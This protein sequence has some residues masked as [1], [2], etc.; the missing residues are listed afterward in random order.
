MLNESFSAGSA[1][2]IGQDESSLGTVSSTGNFPASPGKVDAEVVSSQKITLRTVSQTG[3]SFVL[4]D[5]ESVPLVARGSGTP[6]AS[7][8]TNLIVNPSLEN[9][10]TCWDYGNVAPA[11]AP[12]T[13][14][15]DTSWADTGQTS[16][17]VVTAPASGA[18]TSARIRPAGA[19]CEPSV[20]NG[21]PYS[22]QLRVHI[23]NIAGAS[24][25]MHAGLNWLDTSNT[26]LSGV[27]GSDTHATS[28]TVTLTVS[29][30]APSDGFAYLY[31]YFNGCTGCSYDVNIDSGIVT[32]TATPQPYFDGDSPGGVWNGPRLNSTST[33]QAWTPY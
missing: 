23:N 16:L 19:S 31:L 18:Y 25:Y 9:G 20:T 10:L 22:A 12:S 32:N 14:A 3:T 28:G 33:G 21:Q 24:E 15:A 6:L 27:S 29:G 1:Q 7:P 8:L 13:F 17:H 11:V 4:T 30:T 26:Y 2:L 5:D